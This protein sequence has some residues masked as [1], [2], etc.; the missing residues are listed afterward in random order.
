MLAESPISKFLIWSNVCIFK[1]QTGTHLC[2]QHTLNWVGYGFTEGLKIGR[3]GSRDISGRGKARE[4]QG[5]NIPWK[6]S[7]WGQF[8]KPRGS[9]GYS[10]QG[11]GSPYQFN[12][13]IPWFLLLILASD[14]FSSIY[15]PS[16]FSSKKNSH[17]DILN[18]SIFFWLG[19]LWS[20]M[21]DQWNFVKINAHC[22]PSFIS[23]KNSA[24]IGL[25]D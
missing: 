23:F 9:W 2:I 19:C 21:N 4:P 13:Y 12:V 14:F 18:Y 20:W 16:P 17:E 8:L 11:D 15:Y 7:R 3:V 5:K 10:G 25:N 24:V 22:K 1:H 6:L